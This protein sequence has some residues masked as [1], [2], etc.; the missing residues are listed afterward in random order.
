M[1]QEFEREI[2]ADDVAD[3]LGKGLL[4]NLVSLFRAEPSLYP[5]IGELLADEKI[6]SR[7]GASA[8]VETLVEEDPAHAHLAVQALTPLLESDRPLV[9]GDAAW[10]LGVIGRPEALAGLQPLLQDRDQGVREAAAEA[11]ESIEG[12]A[13]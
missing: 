1:S 10:L 2:S 7:V 12:R 4:E 5:L 3:F 13:G 8:L 9:R 11:V 6:A